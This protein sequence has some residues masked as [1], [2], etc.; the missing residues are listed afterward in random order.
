MGQDQPVGAFGQPLGPPSGG[1]WPGGQDGASG[2]GMPPYGQPEHAGSGGSGSGRSRRRLVL[3]ALVAAAALIGGAVG[4]V[5]VHAT[6][7]GNT[8]QS[9]LSSG[10]TNVN[11][12]A[13]P[14][15]GNIEK[16]AQSVQP[17]VVTLAAS[18]AN[19]QEVDT[20]SGI[21]LSSD[22][23]IVTNNHVVEA[24]A[25]G[26]SVQV[27]TS[28]GHNYTAKIVGRDE[29]S[30]LAVIKAQGVKNLTPA[31]LGSST[32]LQVGQQVVAIGAPLDLAGTVTTGI[33][34][35]LD[36]PVNTTQSEEQE[37]EELQGQGQSGQGQELDPFGGEE[38]Q[39]GGGSETQQTPTQ[40]TVI[41]AIQT[42]A[43]INPGNSGGAL[44]DMNGHV[45][46]INSAIASVGSSSD[47][48]QSGSI[49]V[50][51]AIPISEAEP[52]IKDLAAGKTVQ[53]AQ[54]D[55]TVEDATGTTSGAKV[56]SV[57]SGGAAASAGLKPGDVVTKVDSRSIQ[58]SDGLVAAIRAYQP[59]NKVTITY[60]R[61]GSTH[62]STATLD[63]STSTT[64]EKS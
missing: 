11:P 26:G 6:D 64:G 4:G 57:T 44:I 43:A 17:S 22:G 5:I 31:V 41:D 37:Q 8:V 53:R 18:E 49:G 2:G 38:G 19:G 7:G 34:S 36:R 24:A 33:V 62:T 20:G 3:P 55:V 45:V 54:L 42:D 32:S 47:A 27:S 13:A 35:A 52:I 10:S 21:V 12:A 28:D 50:G 63:S 60:V 48:S 40:Q 25:N 14:A 9:S 29:I 15:T 16:V 23:L 39:G 1:A 46:G 59:G 61:G 30:D 58:D 51:F 56:V